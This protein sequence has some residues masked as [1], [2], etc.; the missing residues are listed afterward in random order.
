MDSSRRTWKPQWKID[1]EKQ[2]QKEIEA[3]AELAKGLVRTETNFP[4]LVKVAPVPITSKWIGKTSF[5]DLA[6]EW[7]E[8]EDT[9]KNEEK[10]NNTFSENNSSQQH[11]NFALPKFNALQRYEEEDEEEQEEFIKNKPSDTEWKLV[12]RT[13]IKKIKSLE[14]LAKRP[15]SPEEDGTVWK[16]AELHETCWEERT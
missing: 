16:E 10:Q 4:S 3:A 12:D 11:F 15:P 5:K 7:N 2:E 8:L 14:E 9:R 13:K 1:K 6:T